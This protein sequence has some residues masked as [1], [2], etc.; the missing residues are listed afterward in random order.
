MFSNPADDKY[1]WVESVESEVIFLNDFRWSKEMISWKELLLL[2]EGQPVH[3]IAPKN[4]FSKDVCLTR[5]T[6]VFATSIARVQFEKSGKTNDVENDMMDARW[7][8]F[9]FVHEISKEDEKKSD[10]CGKCFSDLVLLGE[11]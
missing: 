9:E 3:F 7:K 4:H 5:D 10:P 8:V 2:L 1:A 6:P 11:I